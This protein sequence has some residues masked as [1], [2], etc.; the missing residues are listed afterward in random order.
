MKTFLNILQN[1]VILLIISLNA[2]AIANGLR[3][4]SW[5]G[6]L[7]SLASLV[8]LAYCIHI[9]KKIKQLDSEEEYD[10]YR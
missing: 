4:S 5:L 10:N 7:L 1:T 6:I 8:A 9:V 2:Y 3:L